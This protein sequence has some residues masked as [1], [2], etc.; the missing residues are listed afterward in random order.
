MVARALPGGAGCAARA[1]ASAACL[2]AWRAAQGAAP[3]RPSLRLR[4]GLDEAGPRPS[5]RMTGSVGAVTDASAADMPRV[6]LPLLS[7][8]LAFAL[9]PFGAAFVALAAPFVALAAPFLAL[10]SAGFRA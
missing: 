5:S 4:G 1:R 2:A 6:V 3:R 9:R 8:P 10:L 7:L